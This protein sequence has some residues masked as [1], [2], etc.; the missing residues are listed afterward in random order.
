M[1]RRRLSWFGLGPMQC[2]ALLSILLLITQA[3]SQTV[4][5][6]NLD[7]SALGQ[8]AL[9]GNFDAISVYSHVGQQEGFSSN[10]T[11]SVLSQLP[12]GTYEVLSSTDAS[13]GAVCPLV[14][15]DGSLAGLVV[16]GNFTSVG[17]VAARSVAVFNTTTSTVQP[18]SGVEG[19]VAALFCDQDTE[20]VYVGGSF[21]AQNSTNAIAWTGGSWS[22]LP[23]AGFDAPVTSITKAPDGHIIF[24]G[25]FTGLGNVSTSIQSRQDN[26]VINLVSANITS[27]GNTTTAGF[28]DAQNIVCPSNGTDGASTTWLLEDNT[29]GFWRADLG[30]GF[31]PTK[32]RLWNT[33]EGGR[34][35]KT[36]HFTAHPING[37]MNF[38]YTDPET[39]E[40]AYCDATCPLAHNTS[41]PYQDF[42]FV[43]LVGMN[44]FTI[45][46][47]DWYG[48]GG[49]LDG[50]ELFQSDIFAYAIDAFNE[51]GCSGS[52]TASTATATG[53]W[54]TTPSRQSVSDYLTAVVGPTTVDTA[55]VVFEPDVKEAGNYSIIVYTPGC[56]QDSSCSARAIV[57]V[58]GTLTSDGS[59][60]FSTLLYQTNDFD[61]YDQVFQGR[62]DAS[63]SSFR[64]S[65]TITPSG[66]QQDQLIVA[67]RVKFT[68]ISSTGGLNGLF[69]YDPSAAFV[70][71][72]FSQS[73]ID[74]GGMM[75]HSNA[76]V[77]A[78]TTH[79]QTIFAAGRFSND[80]FEN[81]M[82]FSQN[83][84]SSLPGGGLDDAVTALYSLDDFLYVGGNFSGTH[85]GDTPGLSN[86]AAYQYSTKAWV[87][88][89]AGLNGPIEAIVPLPLNISQDT[90][91]TVVA[92]SGDFSQIQ[93]SGSN[94]SVQA[95]GLAIWVPSKSVWLETLDIPKQSLAGQL[96]AASYLPNNTWLGAGTLASQGQAIS[97]A[98]GLQ[99]SSGEVTLSQLPIDINPSQSQASLQKRALSGAQNVTGVTTGTYYNNGG[100]NVTIL[101]GHFS[102]TATNGSTIDN[103]L[104]LNGSDNNVVTGPPP[105]IDIN[106]TVLSLAVQSDLLFVG[107]SLTG[108]VNGASIDGLLLYDLYRAAYRNI[109]PAALAGKNVVVNAIATPPSG[110]G[111][112]VGGSFDQTSQGL[113]CSRV[114]MYDTA[115]NQWNTVGGGL[116]GTVTTLFW[117][118]ETTLLAA[119]DLT[120]GG[121][122]TSLASYNTKQQ[123]WSVVQQNS[124]IPG[125]V[126]AFAPATDN[127]DHMWV[128]GSATN[129]STY[130]ME[131]DGG[132][133][134]PV[135]G[136][137]GGGTSIRSLQILS[138][139]KSHGSSQYL[140]TDQAL[141]VTGQLNLTD[142]GS[143]SAALFNGTAMTP[144]ILSSTANGDPGSISQLLSSNKNNL[145]SSR[146]SSVLFARCPILTRSRPRPFSRHRRPRC[147]VC[148]T[149]HPF[150]CYSDRHHSQPHSTAA[151]GLQFCSQRTVRGQKFEHNSSAAGKAVWR[152]RPEAWCAHCLT[153]P[154]APMFA[155]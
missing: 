64:P 4:P 94:Q 49:G 102:A 147:P 128:A 120:V 98:V 71:T 85:Q 6:P 115:T 139:T 48:Q 152:L 109:Q 11:Q 106:S 99:S 146:K 140:D 15:K 37:I 113:S 76:H 59:S 30:F 122:Q 5:S 87:P 73:A 100:R 79:E 7:L 63:S 36:W 119:G 69:D 65:V 133:H 43:N 78:L 25:S 32:L 92:F 86:V 14:L 136:V 145:K 57:N 10:G 154:P 22:I 134:R 26:Q 21:E 28:G 125:P 116:G 141:L 24:G 114:C 55:S 60:A 44:S 42:Y 84:T 103:L 89:G 124:A 62:V 138:L 123:S 95:G 83:L 90:A 16:G 1:R 40:N 3:R 118:S 56:I 153:R 107:G 132:N 88:L 80:V 70:S 20:I 74:M 27:G 8:V 93:A 82:A 33:N 9:A 143:A 108:Q 53:P 91:E 110:T 142:F 18:L 2:C 58:T 51:P 29:P 39:G 17:G 135:V 46:V 96:F 151:G 137:F 150:P 149:R 45:D 61:K 127:A 155:I 148:G 52:P 54:Y 19:T 77:M 13:I 38:T 121:N 101:G 50:I 67:S 131:I 34:G 104:F 81:I 12:D 35:T 97:D 23:F 144:F 68:L 117:T 112:Y 41:N 126:S 130:L 129:G 105:G 47:S 75:L 111:V 72:D 31:Q 66:L